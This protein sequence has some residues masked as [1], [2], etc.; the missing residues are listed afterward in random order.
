MYTNQN[1]LNSNTQGMYTDKSKQYK[2][3]KRNENNFVLVLVYG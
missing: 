3:P 1:V 2:Y